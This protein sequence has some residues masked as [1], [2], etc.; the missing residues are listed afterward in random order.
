MCFSIQLSSEEQSRFQSSCCSQIIQSIT[1]GL[2]HSSDH[3]S[4]ISYIGQ[5]K[6]LLHII[7]GIS[8]STDFGDMVSSLLKEF[9]DEG[10]IKR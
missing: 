10:F 2:T 1:D 4:M 3:Y 6:L 7:S 5:F 8:K 9:C